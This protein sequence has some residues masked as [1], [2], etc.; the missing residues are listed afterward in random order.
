MAAKKDN[1][2]FADTPMKCKSQLIVLLSLS[3]HQRFSSAL[4]SHLQLQPGRRDKWSQRFHGTYWLNPGSDRQCS[5]IGTFLLPRFFPC[6]K[7]YPAIREPSHG[8]WWA[9][10][11]SCAPEKHP[12]GA[13][14][15]ATGSN[16]HRICWVSFIPS[17]SLSS[18][19][20]PGTLG[21]SRDIFHLPLVIPATS[22]QGHF[23]SAEIRKGRVRS[24]VYT[25]CPWQAS[26]VSSRSP[27]S[28]PPSPAPPPPPAMRKGKCS[29]S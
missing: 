20:L 19:N 12:R 21:R 24:A 17:S 22:Q 27:H 8:Q 6:S 10:S 13:E 23:F 11:L 9:C 16:E 29:P 2:L 3:L 1:L 26:K 7:L 5:Q 25:A 14:R 4:H 18:W 15:A 28:A